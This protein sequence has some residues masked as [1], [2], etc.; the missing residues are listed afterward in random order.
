MKDSTTTTLPAVQDSTLLAVAVLMSW[1][2]GSPSHVGRHAETLH[3][4]SQPNSSLVRRGSEVAGGRAS[5]KLLASPR[6]EAAPQPTPT[7]GERVAT[8]L[9]TM[10]TRSSVTN[11]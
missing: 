1:T 5:L 7:D 10:A 8:W 6:E 2:G 9:V 3:S 11:S 4:A